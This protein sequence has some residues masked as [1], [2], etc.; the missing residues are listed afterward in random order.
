M[1]NPR[2]LNYLSKNTFIVTSKESEYNYVAE[3]LLDTPRIPYELE[4]VKNVDTLLN[5]IELRY[6]ELTIIFSDTLPTDIRNALKGLQGIL[7]LTL[8]L[9]IIEIGSALNFQTCD[10]YLS[11]DII[12]DI[13]EDDEAAKE[14]IAEE[15]LSRFTKN[16]SKYVDKHGHPIDEPELTIDE[17]NTEIES[18]QKT[19]NEIDDVL[20]S[21]TPQTPSTVLP[22]DDPLFAVNSQL[23]DEIENHEKNSKEQQAA[24]ATLERHLLQAKEQLSD[25]HTQLREQDS[26]YTDKENEL[27]EL[28]K[29][30]TAKENALNDRESS[31]NRINDKFMDATSKNTEELKISRA[32]NETLTKEV[33]ELKHEISTQ[34]VENGSK[35]ELLKEQRND[36]KKLN[37]EL[38]TYRKRLTDITKEMTD[39]QSSHIGADTLTKLQSELENKTVTISNLEN[40]ISTLKV[41]IGKVRQQ[42]EFLEEDYAQLKNEYTNFIDEGITAKADTFT[43]YSLQGTGLPLIMYFK[44]ITQPAYFKSFVQMLH[45]ELT[46]TGSTLIL[47]LREE[48][49]IYDSYYENVERFN[50]FDEIPTTTTFG[51]ITPNRFMISQQADWYTQFDNIVIIDYTR[52]KQI[53]ID[54]PTLLLYY[55]YSNEQEK[56]KSHYK[57]IGALYAGEKSIVDMSYDKRYESAKNSFMKTKLI[58]LKVKDWLSTII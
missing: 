1:I 39:L 45:R 22:T 29:Q 54:S 43:T 24:Y 42:H 17:Q 53:F 31:I 56:M 38:V 50:R 52:T 21:S 10:N 18:H 33:Q 40:Q 55:T 34:K 15:E 30:L 47:F 14:R 36:I 37:E 48:D 26:R 41:D 57:G 2:I 49:Y 9:K 25:A 13:E 28:R 7:P 58:S 35:L 12:Y 23:L 8:G 44:V 3:I 46:S 16:A 32:L 6:P 5:I 20:D 51:L 19:L 27:N 4:W 11:L